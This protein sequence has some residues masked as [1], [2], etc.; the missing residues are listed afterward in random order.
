MPGHC[1]QGHL[2]HPRAHPALQLKRPHECQEQSTAKIQPLLEQQVG[3]NSQKRVSGEHLHHEAAQPPLAA[4]EEG[5]AGA[6]HGTGTTHS[7]ACLGTACS[8]GKDGALKGTRMHSRPREGAACPL[9][10]Q[11]GTLIQGSPHAEG[12]GN[13]WSSCMQNANLVTDTREGE[14]GGREEQSQREGREDNIRGEK[15][16][17]KTSY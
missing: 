2:V 14:T 13:V 9:P 12:Q 16:R 17:R 11:P 15:E 10:L 7:T 6:P 4:H 8:K 3:S 1:C 5:S